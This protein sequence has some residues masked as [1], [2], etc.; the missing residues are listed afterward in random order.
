MTFSSTNVSSGLAF[1]SFPHHPIIPKTSFPNQPLSKMPATEGANSNPSLKNTD[2]QKIRHLAEF[3]DDIWG[4][5]FIEFTF[6][7]QVMLLLIS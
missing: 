4:D 1:L 6:D 2:E 3:P 5:L 7:E